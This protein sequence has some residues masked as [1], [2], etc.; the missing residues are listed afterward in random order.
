MIGWTL[1]LSKVLAWTLYVAFPASLLNGVRKIAIQSIIKSLSNTW[2]LLGSSKDK[3]TLIFP[4][5]EPDVSFSP[6]DL[7]KKES[8][9]A[10]TSIAA[11]AMEEI[12]ALRAKMRLC[13]GKSNERKALTFPCSTLRT[14]RLKKITLCSD[15]AR[16]LYVDRYPRDRVL[17][18]ER[19]EALL[20]ENKLKEASKTEERVE[21]E[22][23][24]DV[25]IER[26]SEM[27]GT[28]QEQEGSTE[29]D[30]SPSLFSEE[31]WDPDKIDETEEIRVNGKDKIKEKFHSH[32]TETG[33]NCNCEFKENV[34]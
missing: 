29:E 16:S 19:K 24:R 11:D 12:L 23:E 2:G 30:P 25:E 1:S 27:K 9:G 22:E 21:S 3:M 10:D 31:R 4:S 8:M 20:P 28:K 7:T 13:R 18:G 33:Y 5:M 6:T 14:R 26:A 17:G 32:L 34:N 15:E